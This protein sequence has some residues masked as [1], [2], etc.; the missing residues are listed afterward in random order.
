[1][2]RVAFATVPLPALSPFRHAAPV[3]QAA[4]EILAGGAAG[5]GADVAVEMGLVV[6]AAILRQL[7]PAR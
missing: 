4:A 2:H 1:M 5:K 7:G 6:V 3:G